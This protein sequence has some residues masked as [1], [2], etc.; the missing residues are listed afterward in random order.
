MNAEIPADAFMF[1]VDEALAPITRDSLV[2]IRQ[3]LIDYIWKDVKPQS[4]MPASIT[5]GPKT[6][7]MALITPAAVKTIHVNSTDTLGGFTEFSHQD[8]PKCLA[9]W[10]QGHEGSPGNTPIIDGAVS[11]MK[12]QWA[13]GCDALIVPMPFRSEGNVKIDFG[14]KGKIWIGANHDAMALIESEEFS[15]YRLF[16]DPLFVSLNWLERSGYTYDAIVMAGVSGGGWMSVVYPAIDPRVTE[17]V[18]VAGSFPMFLRYLPTADVFRDVGDW[19]QN[20]A[21]FYR[22]AN[23]YEL[24]LLSALGTGRHQ[25]LIYNS[26]DPCCFSGIRALTF[27]PKL[28]R[29]AKELRIDIKS[30][31]DNK[32]DKHDFSEYAISEVLKGMNR[33]ASAISNR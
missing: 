26:E 10:A 2:P 23:Y 4:L 24:Y 18:S 28:I 17:A 19:E 33:E 5:N 22:I 31:I 27:L 13:R 6:G 25:T 20:Y 21:R 8:S 32:E 16:F 7:N 30:L 3:K 29:K 15:A 14:K 11:Y 12:K 9:I 1:D